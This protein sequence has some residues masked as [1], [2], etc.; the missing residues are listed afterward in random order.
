[1]EPVARNDME[2]GDRNDKEPGD[3]NDKGPGNRNDER[4]FKM[5]FKNYGKEI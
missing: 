2:L 4:L 3:R 1:M 5:R